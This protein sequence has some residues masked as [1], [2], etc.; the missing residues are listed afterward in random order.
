MLLRAS[1][2]ARAVSARLVGED[3]TFTAA[4]F[5][6]RTVASGDLFVAVRGDPDGHDFAADA[7]ERGATAVLCERE[8][9]GIGATQIIVD[10]SVAALA[11]IAMWCRDSLESTLEGRVVGITGSVG[12]T[13]TKDLLVAAISADL[14]PCAASERSF[15]NQLGVPVTIIGAPDSARALVLEMGMSG[16]GEIDSLCAIARPTIGVV[17]AVADAHSAFVD[18]IEGCWARGRVDTWPPTRR[19]R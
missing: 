13:S 7:I 4:S 3:A 14:A 17:T 16:Y 18:G 9:T 5:D 11:R 8:L 6:S 1:A 12:K 19:S 15:N 10:D 2:V